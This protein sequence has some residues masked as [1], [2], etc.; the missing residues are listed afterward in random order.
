MSEQHPQRDTVAIGVQQIV[1]ELRSQRRWRNF[2]RLLLVFL[3]IG[4]FCFA[5]LSRNQSQFTKHPS[6]TALVDVYGEIMED[7]E[8]DADHVVNSLH[9]AFKD[10]GTKGIVLRINSPGGSA[11]QAS[12]IYNAIRRFREQYPA[13]KIY[14]VCS[15]MCASA[16]YY[17]ASAT[18]LIYANPMS[19]V[20]SIGVLQDG[21]GFVDML[22]KLGIERR[23][24][25]AGNNKGEMDPFS[26]L[27]AAARAHVQLMLDDVHKQ[28][29]QDVKQGRGK[30]LKA[31]ALLF[32]GQAWTGSQAKPLG[33]IDGFASAGEIAR[34][35]IHEEQVVNYTVRRNYLE[36]FAEHFGTTLLSQ[37]VRL[38]RTPAQGMSGVATAG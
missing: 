23:L 37:S 22:H 20:G 31:N 15:D 11:V 2:W 35:V 36:R 19:V 24:M 32:S 34:D 18:D 16:A 3:L 21:F 25:T 7:A 6:H 8:A 13:V 33:L 28:F 12:Y 26:P 1:A 38:L 29:I 9:L 4:A 10:K 5:G 14:A 30:R 17:I 27:T